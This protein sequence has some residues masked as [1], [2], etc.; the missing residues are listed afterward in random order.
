MFEERIALFLINE[1]SNVREIYFLDDKKVIG[2][3]F[4]GEYY[5]KYFWVLLKIPVLVY[6]ICTIS[7][8][9]LSK[10][11]IYIYVCRLN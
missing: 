5:S 6:V 2:K 10:L 7:F 3:C 9:F 8:I 1:S 4:E 11:N